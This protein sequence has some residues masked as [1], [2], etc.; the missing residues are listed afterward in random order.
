MHRSKEDSAR[1]IH[2]SLTQECVARL[3]KFQDSTVVVQGAHLL[4]GLL[5]EEEGMI[6]PID[7]NRKRNFVADDRSERK[8]KLLIAGKMLSIPHQGHNSS[9]DRPSRPHLQMDPAST[10]DYCG[11]PDQEIT[12]GARLPQVLPLQAGFSDDFLFGELLNF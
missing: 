4:L 7:S 10:D 5:A 6:G 11:E 8:R 2:R 3:Q 12:A 1:A 9:A